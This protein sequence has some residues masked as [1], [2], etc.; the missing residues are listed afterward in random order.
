[1]LNGLS[2]C[3]G[4]GG[5]ELGLRL[6]FGEDIYRPLLYVER[7]EYPAAVLRQRMVEGF[8]PEAPIWDDIKTLSPYAPPGG[9]D[10]LTAGYPCQPFSALSSVHGRAGVADPRH[11]WPYINQIIGWY[12]PRIC[13]F[14]NVKEH[15]KIGFNEVKENLEEHGYIVE[16]DIFELGHPHQRKRL[17]IFAYKGEEI[18][19]A[20]QCEDCALC[21]EPYCDRCDE[22]Y[23]DC[24]CLGP[25]QA[26]DEGAVSRTIKGR[27][28]AFPLADAKRTRLEGF[29]GPHLPEGKV[30]GGPVRPGSDELVPF[31][32][33]PDDLPGWE[34]Y[35]SKG[36]G[37]KPVV[38]GGADG[39]AHRV[40]RIKAIGGGVVPVVAA[41]AFAVLSARV[42]KK[43]REGA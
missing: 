14:E 39:L 2:L 19:F 16:H 27:E 40:D 21:D 9:I 7:E 13:F 35:L 26:V 20:H 18:K 12:R 15:Q 41:W 34:D 42:V 43:I 4:V 5:L 33:V 8:L 32:P 30:T 37:S 22:H 3:T 6:Y 17:F 24:G 38:R 36:L 1:M 29:T 31:P 28:F 11:L 10:I 23:A 25:S